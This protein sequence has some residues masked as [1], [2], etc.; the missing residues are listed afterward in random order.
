MIKKYKTTKN[1]YLVG[2]TNAGKS[3]LINKIIDNY[4]IDK[5]EITISSMP[6]TTLNSPIS[7]SKI[8]V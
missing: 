1:V 7:S 8:D 2:N 4:S 3:T 6:S 5:A